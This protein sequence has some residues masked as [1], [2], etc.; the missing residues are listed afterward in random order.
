LEGVVSIPKDLNVEAPAEVLVALK[1]VQ[2]L[3]RIINVAEEAESVR[4]SQLHAQ[5]AAAAAPAQKYRDILAN[6]VAPAA[7]AASAAPAAGLKRS[8]SAAVAGIKRSRSSTAAAAAAAAAPAAG[9]NRSLSGLVA[10][11]A[12]ELYKRQRTDYAV[13]VGGRGLKTRR[14]KRRSRGKNTYS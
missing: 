1:R 10:E 4:V 6:A 2:E 7:R 11:Q 9:L 8:S 13:P 3:Q 14:L 12:E 5:Q